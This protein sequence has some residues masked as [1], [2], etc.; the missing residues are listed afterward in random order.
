ML[1][2]KIVAKFPKQY[3]KPESVFFLFCRRENDE[4]FEVYLKTLKD[5]LTVSYR[6][7]L[8]DWSKFTIQDITYDPAKK[9]S[10]EI[11]IAEVK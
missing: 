5:G 10:R 9:K 1:P 7:S 4:T 3:S 6:T 11:V 8:Q 2:R